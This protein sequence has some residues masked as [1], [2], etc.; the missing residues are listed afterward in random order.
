MRVFTKLMAVFNGSSDC[1]ADNLGGDEPESNNNSNEQIKINEKMEKTQNSKARI[2]NLII[3][4]ESG[5]MT[6]LTMATLTGVNETINTIREAQR[7]YADTQEHYLTLVT[8]DTGHS[9]SIRPVLDCVPISEVEEFTDCRPCGATPLYDAMGQSL[10][11]LYNHIKDDDDASAVVTVLT[12]GYENA[13][14]EWSAA[15]LK[16]FIEKLK[17]EVWSFSYMGA[18]HD[19]EKVAFSLSINNYIQFSH[20]AVGVDSSWAREH[21]AKDEYYRKMNTEY[22][23]RH[24]LSKEEWLKRKRMLADEYY[25]KRVTP[26]IINSLDDS[27]IFVFGSNSQGLHSDGAAKTAHLKFGAIM[28]QGEGLQGRSYAIPTTCPLEQMKEAVDRFIY[29]AR[30]HRWMRFLVTRVGCGIAGHDVKDVAPMFT[31]CIKLENVVLTEEFWEVLG[32]KN[33]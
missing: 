32:L 5:S 33:F 26:N 4:D 6:P 16:E 3:V 30:R 14:V 1:A 9:P 15:S 10:T 13:S 24:K 28:G 18:D 8:F 20:D 25:S 22:R 17:Q 11:I 19:V 31:E 7:Q 21:S 27:E 12:D 23:G 2:Y 29:F